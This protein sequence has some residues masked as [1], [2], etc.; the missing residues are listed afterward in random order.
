MYHIDF[1]LHGVDIFL[2]CRRASFN[3]TAWIH[4]TE[5][6]RLCTTI[7]VITKME[8]GPEM[9]FHGL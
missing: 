4:I 8:K 1:C 6:T 7:T 3:F 5:Q 2:P 9:C